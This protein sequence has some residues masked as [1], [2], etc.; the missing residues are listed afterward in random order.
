[1]FGIDTQDLQDLKIVDVKVGT[2]AE[3]KPG[4][5]VRV[6]YTGWLEDG[7]KFDSSVDRKEPFEFPLGAGYVIQGCSPSV[8]SVSVSLWRRRRRFCYSSECN[9]DF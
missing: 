5:L 7:T 1:M 9:I 2:G 6:H 3:A 8:H 4:E